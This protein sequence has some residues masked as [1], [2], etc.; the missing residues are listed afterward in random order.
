MINYRTAIKYLDITTPFTIKP[1]NPDRG[2]FDPA[3]FS[4]YT[5]ITFTGGV[6]FNKAQLDAVWLT[7]L[8]T[9]CKVEIDLRTQELILGGFAFNG[10]L[11][12]LSSNAQMN[13]TALNSVRDALTYPQAVSTSDDG[14]YQFADAI[15]LNAFAMTALGTAGFHY[16]SGR[17]LKVS[18]DAAVDE[19]AINAII[20][21]R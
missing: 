20:D 5:L 15:E 9:E 1:S 7:I 19:V 14:E 16:S 11:F 18:I 21:T 8:K 2:E 10:K 17:T 3:E 6:S 12:S 13:W 4:D